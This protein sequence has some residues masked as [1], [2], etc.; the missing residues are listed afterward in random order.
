MGTRNSKYYCPLI[1]RQA[2]AEEMLSQVNTIQGV[3]DI[4]FR[5]I[6]DSGRE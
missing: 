3:V 4:H 6:S 1:A 2:F 5:V